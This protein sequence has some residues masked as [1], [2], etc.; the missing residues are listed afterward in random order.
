MSKAS[1]KF[2]ASASVSAI[3]VCFNEEDRIRAC[4]ESVSWCD[5]IVVVDSFSTDRTPEICRRDTERFTQ[6]PWMGYRKQKAYAQD[7]QR[8][9]AFGGM[10]VGMGR[11]ERKQ[12]HCESA[13]HE[14]TDIVRPFAVAGEDV[15]GSGAR[16]PTGWAGAG[17]GHAPA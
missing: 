11:A 9:L 4:L 14:D 16:P 10:I 6:H 2:S 7:L 15:V 13:E 12:R 3:I 8:M 17:R 5:E 1:N